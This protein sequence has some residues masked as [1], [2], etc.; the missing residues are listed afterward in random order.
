MTVRRG[1]PSLAASRK[2]KA[3][4]SVGHDRLVSIAKANWAQEPSRDRRIHAGFEEVIQYC[5]LQRTL[6]WF[7]CL[8]AD[9]QAW[10]RFRAPHAIRN[11]GPLSAPSL[12]HCWIDRAAW[13][14]TVSLKYRRNVATAHSWAGHKGAPI[15]GG[16]GDR[17]SQRSLPGPT[18]HGGLGS[19]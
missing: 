2:T 11:R 8:S 19:A 13:A 4:S 10:P 6:G 9:R 16:G 14:E 17:G 5:R 18:I 15:K 7:H 12:N 1:P 3:G